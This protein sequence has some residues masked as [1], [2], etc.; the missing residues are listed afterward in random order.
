MRAAALEVGLESGDASFTNTDYEMRQIGRL[1]NVAGEDIARRT[2]WPG[3]YRTVDARNIMNSS[4]VNLPDD[5]RE[6]AEGGLVW[7]DG[8]GGNSWEVATIIREPEVWQF[9]QRRPSGERYHCFIRTREREH[10]KVLQF[11]PH[12]VGPARVTV[13]YAS[14]RWVD[15]DDASAEYATTSSDDGDTFMI[16]TRL[17]VKGIVWRWRRQKGLPYDDYLSEY[18]AAIADEMKAATGRA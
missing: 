15:V 2:E 18:E 5:F 6:V 8:T 16:P 3:M 9:L 1:L 14:D 12:L 13:A 11:M 10:Q 4:F 7:V 17:L